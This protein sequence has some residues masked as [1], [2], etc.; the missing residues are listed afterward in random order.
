MSKHNRHQP[1]ISRHIDQDIDGDHWFKQFENKLQKAAVQPRATDTSLFDQ[2]NSIMNHRSISK[3]PSVE[4]AVEDMKARSGLTAY[5]EKDINKVSKNDSGYKTTKK[6]AITSDFEKKESDDSYIEDAKQALKDNN[7]KLF[8]K[9]MA[10]IDSKSRNPRINS[11]ESIRTLKYFID[12]E[13]SAVKVPVE[14]WLEYGLGYNKELGLSQED[15][16]KD[17]E[18]TKKILEKFKKTAS[19]KKSEEGNTTP[20]IMIK[21]P[22]IKKTLENYIRDTKGN[23]PIPAIIDKI[24]S[25]HHGDVS[26]AK[27]W[28]DDKL[29]RMV[30]KLNLNAK[31]DNP[32]NF[33]NYQNL[34]TREQLSES[35]FDPSNVDAFHSLNPAKF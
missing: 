35:E 6:A 16:I 15:V 29:I 11:I 28:D 14:K 27:D 1:V 31:K 22:H 7:W 26:D 30:S 3:Y 20:A 8:G 5:L 2:I 32:D 34:G 25:I 21:C 4:A 18:F 12:P 17:L 10:K 24:R 33:Q 23:L 9:A 19:D 13:I